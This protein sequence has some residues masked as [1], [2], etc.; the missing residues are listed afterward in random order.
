MLLPRPEISTATRRLSLSSGI[1]LGRPVFC[2]GPA[3]SNSADR[4]A[5]RTALDNSDYAGLFASRF[6]SSDHGLRIGGRD[7]GHHSNSA[8][9]RPCHLLRRDRTAFLQQGEERGEFPLASVDHGTAVL[10]KHA[11]DVFEKSAAGNVRKPVDQTVANEREQGLH[12]DSRRLEENLTEGYA[13]QE[14]RFRVQVPRGLGNYPSYEGKAVAVHSRARDPDNKV[15][16][17]NAA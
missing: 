16:R 13:G 5:A 6:Q 2:R 9:E 10:R 7:N 12:I 1:V 17:C 3:S 8:I 11:G 4:A 14:W 15:A